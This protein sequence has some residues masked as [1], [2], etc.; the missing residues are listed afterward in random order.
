MQTPNDAMEEEEDDFYAPNGNATQGQGATGTPGKQ[1]ATNGQTAVK[2][3]KMEDELEEG[4]EEEEEEEDDSGSDIDII[5]ERKD[6]SILEPP[7]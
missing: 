5:T 4:E 1:D 3:E 2:D 6:G 7:S